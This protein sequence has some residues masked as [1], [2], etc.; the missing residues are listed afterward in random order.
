MNPVNASH[1]KDMSRVWIAI[2][3]F[4]GV[5]AATVT[6]AAQTQVEVDVLVQRGRQQLQEA[7]KAGTDEGYQKA[8]ATFTE[9]L[10][11]DPNNTEAL[12]YR[13]LARLERSGLLAKQGRFE[14]SGTLTNEAVA[15][16]DRAVSLHPND[17]QAR[18]MRGSS[19]AQFPSFLNKGPTAIEDL[20]TVTKHPQFA[21]QSAEARARIHL[22]LGRAYAAAGQT[23][24]A[25]GSF[26]D[27]VVINAQS[28]SGVAAQ[29]E[30][31]KLGTTPAAIDS[32][33]RR[34][35]DHFAQISSET[36]PVIVAATVTLPTNAK[37]QD[38][39]SLPP[40]MQKFLSQL[41]MQPGLL[42]T[43]MLMSVDHPQMLV[44]MTWWKDKHALNDWFYSDTHQGI[45]KEYYGGGKE[46]VSRDNAKGTMRQSGQIG[47]ELFG[48]LPG[49][50][51]Y[52]GGLA[53]DNAEKKNP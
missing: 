18:L 10:Q 2:A 37:I 38:R 26:G 27:A 1:A 6:A 5:V 41:E 53:P 28:P 11:L 23:E 48:S 45:I 19:Y 40:S 7:R 20:E 15:D 3:L 46:Q 52:G 22:T 42:G 21:S 29:Q 13:G 36:S 16:L 31:E 17:Y 50:I 14:D 49:S 44:I 33:G 43:H 24:K 4:V 12:T 51:R 9:G 25:K 30:L 8:E 39:G 34:R 32:Q 47:M 35:P